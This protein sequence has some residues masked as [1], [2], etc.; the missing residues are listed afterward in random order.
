LKRLLL[1][2]PSSSSSLYNFI[3]FNLSDLLSGHKKNPPK[4]NN[5]NFNDDDN[6][7]DSFVFDDSE[8]GIE[9]DKN[10]NSDKSNIFEFLE[11]KKSEIGVRLVCVDSVNSKMFM[12]NCSKF[13]I[14]IN[15]DNIN[16]LF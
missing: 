8:G 2:Q 11:G 9:S 10:K 15:M 4:I 14:C 3:H 1:F 16:I 13:F 12:D 7:S 6:N 5:N